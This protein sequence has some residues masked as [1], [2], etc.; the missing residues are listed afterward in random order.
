[1]HCSITNI[2]VEAV[3]HVGVPEIFDIIIGSSRQ[4]CCNCRPSEMVEKKGENIID[5]MQLI[6]VIIFFN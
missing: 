2:V 4:L 3:P 6:L 5:L 1:L